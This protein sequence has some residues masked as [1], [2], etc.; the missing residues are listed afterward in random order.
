MISS[1]KARPCLHDYNYFVFSFHFQLCKII[2]AIAN[3]AVQIAFS[4]Q[5]SKKEMR[6]VRQ[7][8][9]S[10]KTDILLLTIRSS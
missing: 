9:F 5:K 6:I 3:C 4:H 10:N 7:T 1:C 2:I 8:L